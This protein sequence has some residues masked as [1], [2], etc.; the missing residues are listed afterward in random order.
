M[1]VVKGNRETPF[2]HAYPQFGFRSPLYTELR[3]DKETQTD[4]QFTTPRSGN[5]SCS[6]QEG[7][8]TCARGVCGYREGMRTTGVNKVQTDDPRPQRGGREIIC[9]QLVLPVKQR[10]NETNADNEQLR[11]GN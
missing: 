3:E 5:D 2:G 11:D 7:L 8:R 4:K 1:Q 9:H 10:A 6:C